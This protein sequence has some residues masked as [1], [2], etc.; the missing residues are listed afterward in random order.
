MIRRVTHRIHSDFLY[1]GRKILANQDEVEGKRLVWPLGLI[2]DAHCGGMRLAA[3]GN[4]LSIAVRVRGTVRRSQHSRHFSGAG[5]AVEVT[6]ED[7]CCSTWHE[8]E[9]TFGYLAWSQVTCLCHGFLMQL[10]QSFNL[11]HALPAGIV[12]QMGGGDTHQT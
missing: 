6:G 7:R 3:M 11:G 9:W 2:V 4:F 5:L 12:F 1:P 8:E 10:A